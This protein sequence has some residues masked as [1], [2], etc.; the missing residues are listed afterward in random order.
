MAVD[1][2]SIETLV[3][4]L[5]EEPL[6]AERFLRL[7][8]RLPDAIAP[9]CASLAQRGYLGFLPF[10]HIEANEICLRLQPGLPL[11][12]THV[13]IAL[14]NVTEALTIAPSIAESVAGVIAYVSRGSKPPAGRD[15]AS[16]VAYGR[17][18]GSTGAV[19][20]ACALL[21]PVCAMASDLD[22]KAAFWAG[23]DPADP[24]FATLAQAWALAEEA[25]AAWADAARHDAALDIPLRIYV[26]HHVLRRTG[27][28]V[29]QEAW[30]LVCADETV[31]PSYVGTNRGARRSWMG[32]PLLRAIQYLQTRQAAGWTPPN[33]LLW[34]AAEAYAAAPNA[35]DGGAHLEAAQALAADDPLQA[36]VQARNA[37]AFHAYG[38]ERTPKAAIVFAHDLAVR[39]GW[40]DLAVTLGW[41]RA[42]LSI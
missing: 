16:L 31:D 3:A 5:P 37:A 33:P 39:H 15:A 10:A 7:R 32:R 42:E 8:T 28:D 13:A 27:V 22:R 35:Y 30:R 23:A 4:S 6:T 36:F 20:A 2:R 11:S 34:R 18:F 26:C 29:T 9:A 19:D 12:Q 40:G 38:A 1:P 17:A 14:W 21:E 24:V 41:A 25:A